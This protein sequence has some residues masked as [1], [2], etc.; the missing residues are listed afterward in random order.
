MM[1]TNYPIDHA[2]V[3]ERQRDTLDHAER[4]RRSRGSRRRQSR[5]SKTPVALRS[6]LIGRLAPRGAGAGS[7]DQ[8][9]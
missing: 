6:W 3:A 2:L 9:P 4:R 5:L 8:L 1:L 7:R